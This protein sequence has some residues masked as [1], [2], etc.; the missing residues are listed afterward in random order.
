MYT[1]VDNEIHSVY[2]TKHKKFVYIICI[3]FQKPIIAGANP[4]EPPPEVLQGMVLKLW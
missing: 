3:N 1:E 2:Y 4:Q